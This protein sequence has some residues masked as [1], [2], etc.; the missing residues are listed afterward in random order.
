MTAKLFLER[1][2]DEP[3]TVEDVSAGGRELRWCLD[4]HRCRWHGSFLALDGRALICAFSG[5][6]MESAR[7]ALRDPDVDLSHFWSGTE[8]RGPN[9]VVPNVVVERAFDA[10]VRFEDIKALSQAAAWCLDTYKVKY[11]HS[12]HSLDGKRML[13][14][15]SAPDAEAVRNVQREARAPVSAI[16]AGTSV[17]PE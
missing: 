6:D 1:T 12:V 17:A 5:P 4:V 14:F 16:W 9:P 13:C 8:Y 10:P 2:F 11:S 7:V 3:L 15:Y